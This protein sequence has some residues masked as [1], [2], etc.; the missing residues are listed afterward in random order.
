MKLREGKDLF[1]D[2]TASEW[3]SQLSGEVAK[4]AQDLYL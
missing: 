4:W 1:S 3:E 2:H